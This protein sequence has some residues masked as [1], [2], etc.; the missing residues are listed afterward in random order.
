MKSTHGRLIVLLLLLLPA[1][2]GAQPPHIDPAGIDGALLLCGSYEATPA[3][4]EAFVDL[5][6]GEKAKLVILTF[7]T[8]KFGKTPTQPI[9]EAAQKKKAAEPI[10]IDYADAQKAW[11]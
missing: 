1:R 11:P 10:V 5:A 4:F 2:L 3:M 7:D 9:A 6:G 8:A